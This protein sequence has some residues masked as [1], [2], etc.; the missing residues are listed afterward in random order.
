L[1][2]FFVIEFRTNENPV[3]DFELVEIPLPAC[4]DLTK[5]FQ[6]EENSLRVSLVDCFAYLNLFISF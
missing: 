4:F 2:N 6:S 3:N 5:P 1:K